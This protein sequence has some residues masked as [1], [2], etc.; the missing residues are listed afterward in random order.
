MAHL[1]LCTGSTNLYIGS[2]RDGDWIHAQ[3]LRNLCCATG[4]VQ[5]LAFGA[6]HGTSEWVDVTEKFWSDYLQKGVCAIHGDYAH[7][8]IESESERVCAYCKKREV[9]RVVIMPV[10]QWEASNAS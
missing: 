8:W 6:I 3:Q 7:Q 1:N 10:I 9:K 4:K 5:R 2:D